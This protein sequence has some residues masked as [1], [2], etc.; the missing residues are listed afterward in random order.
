[1]ISDWLLGSKDWETNE[2]IEKPVLKKIYSGIFGKYSSFKE[3]SWRSKLWVDNFHIIS[4]NKSY[5]DFEVAVIA[6]IGKILVFSN[7]D[8]DISILKAT[9]E[10]PCLKILKIAST[11]NEEKLTVYVLCLMTEGIK[12]LV[13]N[14]NCKEC[15]ENP[16]SK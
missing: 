15:Y 1:L 7:F 8:D 14:F 9:F 2:I 4:K 5:G 10:I 11:I 13:L 16:I 3:D 6:V 12:L